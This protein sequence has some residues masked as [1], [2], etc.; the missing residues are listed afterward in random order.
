MKKFISIIFCISLWLNL[1]ADDEFCGLRNTAFSSNESLT[2]TVFYSVIGLYVNA[3]TASFSNRIE[4]LDNKP[5]YHIIALGNSN[6]SYDWIYKVRDRYE[7]FIDTANLQP[8][9]SIRIVD[10]GGHKKDENTIFNQQQNTATTPKGVFN[11][12][13]CTQDVISS[14]YYA[15][16]INFNKYKVNDKIPFTMFLGK[17]VYN[18][19]IKYVGKEVVKTRYGKFNAIKLK[20]L[21]IKGDVFKGGEDMNVWVSDDANHIPLRIESSISV[22]SIKVDMMLYRNLRYPLSSLISTR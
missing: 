11:I 13:N 22:G 16:N 18:L 1:S 10:E 4:R 17:D 15:R 12:P 8:L 6:S 19:Y 3:G 20:P 7:S 5:V 21:L 2:Y 14:I 9:K